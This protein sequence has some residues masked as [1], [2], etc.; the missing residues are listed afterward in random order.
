MISLAGSP[1][2]THARPTEVGGP[3]APGPLRPASVYP[4]RRRSRRARRVAPAFCGGVVLRGL[5][6]L[7]VLLPA[8]LVV[9]IELVSDSVL[10]VAFP[11]PLD[12]LLIGLVVVACSG[13]FSYVAFG[14][15]DAL[16]GELE[17]RNAA[18][19]ARNARA[20]ALH[21]VSVA[22][23]ALAD[24]DEILQAAVDT[25]RELLAADVALLV[26]AMPDGTLE[27][28]AESGPADAFVSGAGE[29]VDP[30]DLVEPAFASSRLGSPLQRGE[31]TVGT[32]AV[33]SA[34]R[35]SFSIDDVETLSSL[36]IQAAIAIENDRLQRRLRE[37]AVVAERERIARE[38][39]DGLA[40]VLGY[41]NTKSQAAG[42]LLA[43]G[44]PDDAQV[45]LDEL[46]AAARS[47]YVDVR[48]AILALR[49]P[50][51]PG[52]ELADALEDLGRRFGEAAKVAVSVE[53]D[54]AAR[55][56]PVSAETEAQ[57]Y[58]IVQEAL[59]NVRKHAAARRV[60]ITMTGT[61]GSIL[62]VVRDDGRGIAAAQADPRRSD[63]DWPRYGLAAM[64]ERAA[65]IGGAVTVARSVEGGTEVRVVA[66]AS[67]GARDRVPASPS[68]LAARDGVP[69]AP[70]AGPDERTS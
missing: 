40:Q 30:F 34:S 70:G 57:V 45:Q 13:V 60:R 64:A 10:D 11:V 26:L 38:M 23:T 21:R 33:A 43:A 58:R 62:V 54:A 32:L 59:T 17:A 24:L 48:E 28:R 49:A 46:A 68:T 25:A 37:L 27:L 61:A 9:A 52:A 15:I 55:A 19:E 66:P 4:D 18:L 39:H 8:I 36:A 67:A 2:T 3:G 16:A 44:R 31:E 35:R 42:E 5:R 51:P 1:G 65:S 12:T 29:R 41:V 22:I 53:V 56:T 7:T 69:V 20:A 14:R 63:G 47:V 50:I 6:W